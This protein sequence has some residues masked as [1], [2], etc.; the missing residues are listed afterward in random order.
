[1]S[2]TAHGDE[3]YILRGHPIQEAPPPEAGVETLADLFEAQAQRQPTAPLFSFAHPQPGKPPTTVSY[4]QAY[5]RTLAVSQ[6][7]FS[8]LDRQQGAVVGVWLERSIEL[9]L[10]LLGVAFSGA[11][12]LPFDADAPA[13]RV[14]VCLQD[15][16]AAIL[17]CEQAHLQAAKEAAQGSDAAVVTWDELQQ[18]ATVE[19][20]RPC[21]PQGIDTAYMIYTSGSTGTPK[22][23]AISH[24]AA[25]TF[26]RSEQ[27]ILRTGPNDVVWQ[28]FSA[29]FDMFI[30]ET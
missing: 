29:A 3:D 1:M 4:G 27:S 12:W 14:R 5:R 28:G 30:E 21:R 7:L 15:S 6:R 25:L 10:A 19:S 17:L 11:G 18:G 13:A 9:H 23:I 22:G 8:L 26:A 16:K 2:N 24:G 20:M